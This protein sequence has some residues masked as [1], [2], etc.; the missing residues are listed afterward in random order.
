MRLLPAREEYV[1]VAPS[2]EVDAYVPPYCTGL[3]C[4]CGNDCH[5]DPKFHLG[6]TG[7]DIPQPSLREGAETDDDQF[8]YAMALLGGTA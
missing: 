8:A 4:T 5:N 1:I 3:I 6:S 2:I 7:Y